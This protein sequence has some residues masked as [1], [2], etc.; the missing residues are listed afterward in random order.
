MRDEEVGK[1]ERVSISVGVRIEVILR[2]VGEEGGKR[3]TT[4]MRLRR[5]CGMK[6]K[7]VRVNGV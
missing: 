1:V 2:V 7:T 5:Y 3:R 4:T 6:K